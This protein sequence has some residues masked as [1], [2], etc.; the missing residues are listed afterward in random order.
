M[1]KFWE[2]F[3]L[4]CT[5]CPIP[6]SNSLGFNKIKNFTH[7]LRNLEGTAQ[8]SSNIKTV[9]A[10]WIHCSKPKGRPVIPYHHSEFCRRSEMTS[11]R[12]KLIKRPAAKNLKIAWNVHRLSCVW[13]RAAGVITKVGYSPNTNVVLTTKFLHSKKQ[14]H[15]ES[16]VVWSD[17]KKVLYNT[18]HTHKQRLILLMMDYN[19]VSTGS[20]E[21]CNYSTFRTKVELGCSPETLISSHLIIQGVTGGTDQ[22]SGGCSLC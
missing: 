5:T 20:L 18:T 12:Q 21:K 16:S 8:G 19:T 7:H 10:Q 13:Q 3:I 22:T 11:N 9:V 14:V 15:V 17:K 6:E 4:P 2:V 1:P